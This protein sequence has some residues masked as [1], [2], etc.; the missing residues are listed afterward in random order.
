MRIQMKNRLLYSLCPLLLLQSLPA[1]AATP[2]LR[3]AVRSTNGS[4]VVNSFDNCVRTKWPS[5]SDACAPGKPRAVLTRAQIAQEERTV[6]FEFNK[7]RLTDEALRKLNSLANKLSS[8][9]Q[10][11]S[12]NIVG[13][14]DRIGTPS[15]NE[16]LSKKRA[17]TV[18]RYLVSRGFVKSQV[19]ETRWLGESEPVTQCA[20]NLSRTELIACLQ[21]DRRVELEIEYQK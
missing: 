4:I 5:E 1:L 7:A 9:E 21:R 17:E 19:A 2:D 20:E 6:Y 12:A 11:R 15:Y 3:D 13:Y 14:A 16:Q 18:R 8:D 10:V